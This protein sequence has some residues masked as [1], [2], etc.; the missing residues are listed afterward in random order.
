MV[1]SK[2]IESAIERLTKHTRLVDF[3]QPVELFP[4]LMTYLQFYGL[5]TEQTD[6]HFG[7]MKTGD[8]D[9][10]VQLFKPDRSKGTI[11]LLHGYLDHVG[12]LR[13]IIR[14]L[15][16]RSYTVVTY[17]LK[18]HGLSSGE[19]ASIKQFAEYVSTLES[20]MKKVKRELPGPYYVI[21]HSTGGA[22]AMNYILKHPLHC[23]EKV[24]LAAPVVQSYLWH[25]S[26]AGF[27]MMKALPFVDAL[28][29][30]FRE[31]SSSAQYAVFRQE[32]PLQSK[33][34]PLDWL[35]ALIAWNKNIADFPP[36]QTSTCLI[37]GTKDRTVDWKYNI[38]F[39]SEK[40]PHLKLNYIEKGGHAL[41]N[42]SKQM[43]DLVFSYIDDFLNE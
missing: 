33:E 31:N 22:I 17:D 1:K 39:I 8:I 26:V 21:G 23:F 41:F 24:I 14:F 2:G 12:H 43:R 10:I 35:G 32:D 36:V 16:E 19:Q 27:Y 3:Q 5:K 25:L 9:I 4:E 6:I 18:G 37:Q 38:G 34:I 11:I 30:K 7:V 28:Q 15:T 13:H 29:R 20:L 42:E 40:L